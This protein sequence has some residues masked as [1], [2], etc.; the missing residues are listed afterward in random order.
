MVYYFLSL[1]V[2]LLGLPSFSRKKEAPVSYYFAVALFI[3]VAGLKTGG[4]TDF[5]SYK[6][7]Y[8]SLSNSLNF[9]SSFEVGFQFLRNLCK[10]LGF[11]FVLFYLLF[12]TISIGTKAFVIKRLVP[13]VF[14]ALMMYL[15]GLFFERDNDGIRQGMSI[16][17]CYLSLYFMHKDKKIGVVLSY[18]V[19]VSF[20]YSSGVFILAYLFD[21]IKIKDFTVAIIVSA[22][23][24]LCAVHLSFSNVLM[25]YIPNEV[26]LMKMEQYS[27]SEDYSAAMGISIGLI[28]RMIILLSFLL[29]H[30]KMQI[31]EKMYLI[32][33]NGFA[34]SLIMSLAF[35]DFV[36][37]AHRLPYAFREFQIF[38]VPYMF[39][40]LNNT[41]QKQFFYIILWAY[42]CVILSR[43]L[44]GD[45]AEVYNSYSNY[46]FDMFGS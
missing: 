25:N 23:F 37:L 15:C 39:T 20:H 34:L 4:S 31:S 6:G 8:D 26:A 5:L 3:I 22:F 38:I 10:I 19:A 33:R 27:N 30:N 14:P 1:V 24:V 2:F 45:G 36:I 18:A 9:D 12:A 11:G 29:L 41:T 35:N 13:Y 44:N 16:A 21:K 42:C 17:F 40:A 46:I 28:F 32:L 7:F 43:F